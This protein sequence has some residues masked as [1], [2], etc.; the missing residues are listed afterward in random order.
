MSIGIGKKI[1]GKG[2]FVRDEAIVEYC[3]GKRVLHVGCT[4]YPFFESSLANGHLLHAK[5]SQVASRVIGID[6]ASEDVAVMIDNGYDARVIDAQT[7]SAHDWDEL[8]DVVLL[9]DVIEH[10]SNP[11][12]VISEARKLLAPH[13]KVV[14]TVPNAF[15]IVR[16]IK[17]FFQYEQVHHDHIAYYSSGVLETLATHTGLRVEES[18]WYQFEARDKRL[19]VRL[20]AAFEK[21]ITRFFP[22]QSEG[23][24]SVMTRLEIN[25]T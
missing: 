24:I 6:I 5:V 15:G 14:I 12:L 2:C 16:Y 10:I 20:S 4:D 8:F 13:G 9:A 1:V 11:G 19:I 3:K 18:S 22:W 17:S 21:L 23:C 7:M 25:E